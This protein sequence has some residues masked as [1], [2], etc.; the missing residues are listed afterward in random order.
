MPDG[1]IP[2]PQVRIPQRAPHLQVERV[3][4]GTVLGDPEIP[5]PF[6]GEAQG[7]VQ[8]FFSGNLLCILDI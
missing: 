6:V 5:Q 2:M 3:I 4:V 8:A 1:R 7:H